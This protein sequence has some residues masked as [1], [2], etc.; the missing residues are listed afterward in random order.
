MRISHPPERLGILAHRDERLGTQPMLERIAARDVPALDRLGP[1]AFL[2]VRTIG[3]GF[4]FT[5]HD[6][7]VGSR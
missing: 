6:E 5:T 7:L 2:G 1:C 3:C 4:P